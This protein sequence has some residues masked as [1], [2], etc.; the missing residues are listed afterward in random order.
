MSDATMKMTKRAA[1]TAEKHLLLTALVLWQMLTAILCFGQG[2]FEF[3][4][5]ALGAGIDAL[6][7]D[8]AGNRL[9]GPSYLAGFY[10]GETMDSL[11]PTGAVTPFLTGA[12]AGYFLGGVV[13]LRNPFIPGGQFA[14]VQVRAWDPRLGTTYEDVMRIGLGGYGE[15]KILFLQS[16]G[17]TG[18]G[19]PGPPALL[20]GLQS[21]SL[22]PIPEPSAALLFWLG[23]PWLL[24]RCWQKS[25]H[26]F[27]NH[28]SQHQRH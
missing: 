23:M 16:G 3:D 6:V 17:G 11:M 7:F 4:N 22:R 21:F 10:A 18:G 13:Q 24:W 27:H 19:T 20:I 14:Y 28:Q 9:Q 15:S 26:G 8:A 5:L 1:S 25:E 12:L 2:T